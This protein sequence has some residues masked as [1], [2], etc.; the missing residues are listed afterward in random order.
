MCVSDN[1][2]AH[3]LDQPGQMAGLQSAARGDEAG[4]ED[5]WAS[6]LS[7]PTSSPAKVKSR[8]GVGAGMQKQLLPSQWS[9]TT[10]SV[11]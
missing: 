7:S 9:V 11:P 10:T 3:I 1:A 8:G 2:T 5:E 4:R 6:A